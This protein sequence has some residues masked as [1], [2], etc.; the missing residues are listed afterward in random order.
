M[1][2]TKLTKLKILYVSITKVSSVVWNAKDCRCPCDHTLR[3]KPHNNASKGKL[4]TKQIKTEMSSDN[5]A[6][7]IVNQIKEELKI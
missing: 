1:G 2:Y 7:L 5:V 6:R 3:I 4:R